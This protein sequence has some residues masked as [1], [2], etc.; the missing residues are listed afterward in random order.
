[1][2]QQNGSIY[3]INPK[4]LIEKGLG[5][6]T[7]IRKYAMPELY[8]IDIDNPFDWKVAELILEEKMLG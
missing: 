8:S 4:S 2:W 3:V 6:F 7:K 1:M 5:H